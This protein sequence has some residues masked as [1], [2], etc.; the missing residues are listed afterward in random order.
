MSDNFKGVIRELEARI[1][2]LEEENLKLKSLLKQDE[3]HDKEFEQNLKNFIEHSANLF[4]IHTP[5]HVLTYLSPQFEQILGYKPEEALIKWRELATDNPINEI[6][7]EITQRAIDT[8]QAQESYEL[9]LYHKSG[10]KI[11]VEIHEAPVVAEGKTAAIVGTATDITKRKQAERDFR[12]NELLMR[13]IAENFPNSYLSIIEKDLTIGFTSGQEFKKQNLDPT[14]FIGMPLEEVFGDKTDIVREYYL[15]TFRGEECEFE[16]F[17]NNQHQLYKTVPLYD[18]DGSIPRILSVVE[19]ITDR[20][21]AEE[22]LRHRLEL[23]QLVAAISTNFI[24][25]TTS[26]ID[27]AVNDALRAIGTSVGVDRSYIFQ[28]SADGAF[29]DNT[30]EW[31]AEGIEPQIDKLQGLPVEQFPWWMQKLGNFEVIHIPKVAELPV[32]AAAEKEILQAQDI[33]SVLVVPMV[34]GG[35]LHG[36]LGFDSVREEKIWPE[37][38]IILLNTMSEVIVN[39]FS[40]RRAEEELSESKERYRSIVEG[41]GAIIFNVNR[42]GQF[43]Y[44][45]EA[46]IKALG[47]SREEI[48]GRFYLKFVYQE[49]KRRIHTIFQ[50]QLEEGIEAANVELRFVN[51]EGSVGWFSFLVN[52]IEEK[53]EIV[54]LRGVAQDI[55]ERKLADQA[56]RDKESRLREAQR[57]AHIGNWSHDL[58]TDKRYWS[59]ESFR[60]SGIEHQEVNKELIFSLIHPDDHAI[61]ISASEKSAKGESEQDH[62]FRI[63][64]PD[65]EVRYI[66][67]RWISSYDESGREIMRVGTHQDI[68]E[69]KKAELALRESEERF[70]QVS[71]NAQE[72]IWEVDVDGLYT[73]SSPIVEKILGYDSDE[74]VDIKHFYDLFLP[75][76][77]ENFKKMAFDVFAKRGVFR[78]FVNRNVHKN[79]EIIWLS[80]S[81]IP[82]FDDK[83]NFRGYRGADTDITERKQAEEALR[84]SEERL[85]VLYN[86]NPSMYFTIS[87]EGIVLSVNKFGAEQL[88]YS[89]EELTG[90]PVL[91]IF[92]EDDK[93]KVKDQMRK[94]L[95]HP[96]EIQSWE[97]RKVRKDGSMLWVRETARAIRGK[98]EKLMV[99]IVCEDITEKKNT[100]EALKESKELMDN[101]LAASAVGISYAKDRK[102]MWA[103]EAMEQLF[104]FTK[105]EDYLWKDT[106]ILYADEEEYKRV[107]QLIYSSPESIIETDA[108]FKRIDGS[109]FVGQIKTNVLDRENPAKGIIVNIIDITELRRLEEERLSLERQ[110]QHA[111]KLES[112]GVLAGGIAHDFNNI[113]MVVLGHAD[114]ALM[115]ISPHSPVRESLQEIEKAARRAADL[116]R[117]MLAYSGK[118]RFLLEH[119]N[120]NELVLE[121]AHLLEVSASKNVVI[122]YNFDD[123]LP[124]F[125]GDA[126]QIRQV[127][128][129]LITN[130]SEAIG[131][132]SGVVALSTGIMECDR[133]YLNSCNPAFTSGIDE[134][135]SEGI[136]VYLEAADTGCGM[137]AETQ[138][139]IFDPF[140]TTKFTGRG[141]GLAA[142]LGI[143]RGH[144]GLV[145][146]YSEIGKGTT[147]KILF[148][149]KSDSMSKIISSQKDTTDDDS[150]KGYGEVLLVDDEE[151]VRTIGKKIL[152]R[153]EFKVLTARDGK[154]AVKI[155]REKPDDIR[156]VLLDMTMPHMDGEEAFRELRRIRKDVK[157]ILSSGYNEQGAT[158][159]FLGKGLAGFIQKPYT[160]DNVR[161]KLAEILDK[162]AG[163]SD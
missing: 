70:Q 131:D 60:L 148:P 124:S 110:V 135:L 41:T 125:E 63:I 137:D 84:L 3:H 88:G 132:K 51:K 68:T 65:G 99:L 25:L 37:E 11:W 143:I 13:T 116:S 14:Q 152:E 154:E 95:G 149:V 82:I 75:E 67:N 134:P 108:R 19:N 71:E 160:V 79:G 35:K 122:K 109:E 21:R 97:L 30:H 12:E 145:K 139:K 10:R 77:R 96:G 123:N 73:Y 159:R 105:K 156:C 138:E 119:I 55:T 38:D 20:K 91:D 83:G 50:K 115:E 28:Q 15:K 53:G 78:E 36:F 32:E 42:R 33:L 46:A 56:L 106:I 86:D 112:L 121:M 102:I 49:D 128:M 24:K 151:G 140:F 136:Y 43:T 118:G 2:V 6:G 147:I 23:E 5:D 142:A 27:P 153:L 8:G 59:E 130:A 93:E 150:W 52:I 129:N 74:I 90:S 62:E 94:C 31:C 48:I 133:E 162:D 69:R 89:V 44:I 72:W 117:Q 64:R 57:I 16:L 18:E 9:E 22:A 58:I 26:E 34:Y 103:N 113:L 66:H 4:Y 98:D 76:D 81:G 146:I 114:L 17:I 87:P 107:G 40:R 39:A 101:I 158:Q 120:L 61:I 163:G 85:K 141:L 92:F 45:N 104:G 47:Y 155:Y 161:I 54:G 111:Q 80:T 1:K 126:T 100:E 29:M 7:Y 144:K 157:V 127:I